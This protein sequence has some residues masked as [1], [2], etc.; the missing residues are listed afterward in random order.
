MKLWRMRSV[1]LASIL[2]FAFGC[3]RSDLVDDLYVDFNPS[4]PLDGS[5]AVDAEPDDAFAPPMDASSKPPP[6]RDGSAP[7][8]MDAAM[9]IEDAMATEDAPF[10]PDDGGPPVLCDPES[11][12]TGC[13]YG[14]ICALGTQT[15]ACGHGGAACRVCPAG[16]ICASGNCF[17]GLR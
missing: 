12:S 16:D 11:C 14:N 6:R 13:C 15:I 3:G 8:R 17:T 9:A 1:L 4:E 7:P 5:V 2:V 10:E